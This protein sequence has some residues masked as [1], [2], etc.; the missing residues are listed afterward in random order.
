MF[1]DVTSTNFDHC[2]KKLNFSDYAA[3][4][5]IPTIIQN[6][7]TCNKENTSITC[8][9]ENTSI[10]CN[11]ENTSITCNKEN[12]SITCNKENTSTTCNKENINPVPL[13]VLSPISS[14]VPALHEA[15]QGNAQDLN[16]SSSDSEHEEDEE[17]EKVEDDN[18][19]NNDNNNTST[20][21]MDKENLSLNVP[22]H[23]TSIDGII[24]ENEIQKNNKRKRSTSPYGKTKRTRWTEKEKE[25][26][27]Q[28]FA[29]HMGNLT[30]PSLR[31]IQE[32]KKKYKCLSH[33]TSPQIK[34]W[35]HN[36]QKT[37]RQSTYE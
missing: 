11:E 17:N 35:I 13:S 2:V 8:N 22:S 25:T 5:C 15:V 27:L 6:T 7:T 28:A 24:I 37:L 14:P 34:T 36:K 31:E 33:R 21:Y 9:K 10:T 18:N 12:T 30:L 4:V 32:I 23:N 1:Y 26:V 29:I 16:E 3:D 20:M 19:N